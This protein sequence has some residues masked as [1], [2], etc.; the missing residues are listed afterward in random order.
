MIVEA[1]WVRVGYDHGDVFAIRRPSRE[2][3]AASILGGI[4]RSQDC[5]MATQGISENKIRFS[6]S[7]VVA[8]E[9]HLLAVGGESK[10]AINVFRELSWRSAQS[11]DL[12]KRR[13]DL[14]YIHALKIVNEVSIRG[15]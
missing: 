2:R 9:G 5:F 14:R 4:A 10:P 8:S 7:G 13:M 15:E 12:I 3:K 11:G 6:L 1:A